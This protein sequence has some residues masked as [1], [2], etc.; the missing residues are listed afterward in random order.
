MARSSLLPGSP[1]VLARLATVVL[2]LALV[3]LLAA[4]GSSTEDDE[5]RAAGADGA[6]TDRGVFPTTVRHRFGSTT[7]RSEPQRIVIVGLTEQDTVLALGRKPIAVTDWYGDQPDATWPWARAMLGGTKPVVLKNDDGFDFER[8][9]SLRPDLIIGTNAGMK[10]AD[11]RKLS[12]LAPTIASSPGSTEFFSRWGDQT[13]TIARALGREARGRAIV[14]RVKRRYAEAGRKHPELRGK[15]ATFSQN[16]FYDGVIYSY[17]DGVNTEF[18]TYLG[19]RVNPKVKALQ[20]TIGEQAAVSTERADILD[21]DV[22]IFATEAQKDVAGLL[23]VSTIRGLPVVARNR[24]IYTDPVLAGALYFTS[25][26][27]LEYALDRLV[28]QLVAATKGRAPRS[29]V[30]TTK[31]IPATPATR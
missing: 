31:T 23:R 14:D 5:R 24:T 22:A 18:L 16:A 7:V 4:C 28:P 25:G 6:A 11:Y 19:M 30:D 1:A 17:P 12:R 29:I 9:A 21:A 2:G 15:T 8:I 26:P 10:S 20:T 3:L 13:I 27:S